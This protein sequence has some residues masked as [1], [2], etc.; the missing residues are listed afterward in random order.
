VLTP[1]RQHDPHEEPESAFMP[2]SIELALEALMWRK[3]A[4][5]MGKAL[6]GSGHKFL[7]SS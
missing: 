1:V 4:T 7:T 6:T 5:H 3:S 2:L